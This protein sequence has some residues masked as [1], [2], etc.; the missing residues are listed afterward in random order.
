MSR[1]DNSPEVPSRRLV[2]KGALAAGALTAVPSVAQAATEDAADGADAAG[3]TASYVN[4]LVRNRAD[5]HIHRHTDGYYY[6]TATAPEYDR[7]ILRRSRTLR[8]LT[9][10]DESVIWKKHTSGDMGAHIWAPEIH[11]IDG[12]WY[13]YFAAAPANDIWAIRIWVLENASRNPFE[14]TWTEKGQLKTAW[15]TFSLDAT[16]FTHRGTRYLAWAQHEPGMD[17]N[18]AVWLSKMANP[19]TLTGPQVRLTTPELDWEVIGF[20]VNEGPSVI[21][22]GGRVFMSYSASATDHHYCLGL[23]TAD[24]DSDLMDPANWSKSP[25]PVFTSNDTTK[26]YGPGHNSF[27]VAEDGRTDVLVY[28]ARQYKEIVGD[29]LN[30]PN[31][32]TRIQKLGWNPDGTPDFGIPV[33]DTPV[34]PDKKSRYT[35]TAFTGASNTDLYVYESEDAF[36]YSLLKGPAYTPPGG[37]LRDPSIMKHTDGS[38]WLV[39]TTNFTGNT[40]GFARSEDRVTWRSAGPRTLSTPG[41]AR[42]WAPEWFVDRDG[43]VHVVVS[44]DTENNQVFRPHLLTATD[45]RLLNWSVPRPLTGLD[46]ANYIDTFIV[47]FRG[48][49][50]AFAKN[51]TTNYVEHAVADRLDGPYRFTGTDDWAGW[52]RWRQG[53]ALV[54]LDNGGW[55]IYFD[56]FTDRK[57][58]FSDSLD[59]LRTWTP[60][61]QLPGLS[62]VVHNVTVLRERV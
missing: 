41:L 49:Y 44:L 4:P 59:G 43:S 5:P 53:Q 6:F 1:D 37:L 51:Q 17:N 22:R 31:R 57:Y 8:G 33:A 11:H 56:G 24:A 39:H 36:T 58:Y 47:R 25:T 9:T 30:D 16:T 62:G 2:L 18:T 42:T 13:I 60:V 54:R 38:Y 20:K 61:Q 48:R 19:W 32:H 23:L 14:G 3:P 26:Q 21:Q 7:I 40:I 52:G 12:K 27:T 29:P 46:Q 35:M 15:E 28:H 45:R 55:R 10:A 34:P 50:H